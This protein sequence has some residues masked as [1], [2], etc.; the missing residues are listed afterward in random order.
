MRE[1]LGNVVEIGRW[2]IERALRQTESM[3]SSDE[4]KALSVKHDYLAP[5]G[6]E[7]RLLVTGD[8]ASMAHCRLPAGHSSRAVRHRT[9]EELWYVISGSGE[10]WRDSSAGPRCDSIRE[11]TSLKISTGTSFQ[12][13]AGETEALVVLIATIPPWPGKDEAEEVP[14]KWVP[15]E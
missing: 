10:I 6:S 8:T 15:S 7:I 14:G 12:F 11:G 2:T 5:D 4:L 13:R 1:R 9:V 3:S